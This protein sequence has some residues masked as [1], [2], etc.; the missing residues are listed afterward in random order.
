MLLTNLAQPLWV[1]IDCNEKLIYNAI[2]VGEK[3][4]LHKYFHMNKDY[5]V[6]CNQ[7]AI[8]FMEKCFSFMWYQQQ[9]GTKIN[10]ICKSIKGS[11]TVFDMQ[12]VAFLS[13]SV[14]T[15]LPPV[16]NCANSTESIRSYMGHK[17]SSL[18]HSANLGGL[19]ACSH[20]VVSVDN[21]GLMFCNVK[22]EFSNHLFSSVMG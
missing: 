4:L 14:S 3:C 5:S 16:Y 8:F 11:N 9:S 17:H 22:M 12:M 21:I 1:S 7:A 15:S 18:N 19:V 2:C 10:D 6:A 20:Q 13:Q